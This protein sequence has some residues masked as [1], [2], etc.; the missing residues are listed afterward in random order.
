MSSAA[1]NAAHQKEW[2]EV[3]GM[4][5]KLLEKAAVVF[6]GLSG[7]PYELHGDVVAQRLA[8]M[9]NKSYEGLT[10]KEIM[11]KEFN[12]TTELGVEI[13][14][15][16]DDLEARAI[17]LAKGATD[18]NE[19]SFGGMSTEE[20]A[21][22]MD[23][24]DGADACGPISAYEA[25]LKEGH[26]SMLRHFT[27]KMRAAAARALG[28]EPP[29]E[30]AAGASSLLPAGKAAA[31]APTLSPPNGLKRKRSASFSKSE[32]L[33]RAEEIRFQRAS[34]KL[35]GVRRSVLKVAA[36]AAEVEDESE[37]NK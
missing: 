17:A 22:A 26:V 9:G 4:V 35:E 32:A 34:E 28:E 27:A 3:E 21:D 25:A 19:T 16:I 7:A 6:H 11:R 5:K 14:K 12:R 33:S 30:D 31:A 37:E 24:A 36:R 10:V 1:Y 20:I 29:K 18:D 15:D 2:D 8:T 13:L 23:N